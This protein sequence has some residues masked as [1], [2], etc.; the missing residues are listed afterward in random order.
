[1]KQRLFAFALLAAATAASAGA[2]T[3]SISTGF[4]PWK[5]DNI[6]SVV[7]TSLPSAWVAPYGDAKWI[8]SKASDSSAAKA[9][10]TFAYTLNIGALAGMAGTFNLQYAGDN[11][12][13]WAIS[14]GT[15]TGA[16][17]CLTGTCYGSTGAAPLAISGTFSTTS[18]ITAWVYNAGSTDNPAG[19]MAAGTATYGSSAVPEP[20]TYSM[21]MIGGGLIA[22]ARKW[23]RQ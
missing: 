3:I 18:V 8:G 1:M 11:N 15:V 22:M 16:T 7:E 12:V 4:A 13:S 5:V 9:N 20:S 23:K 17:T 19:L 6:S 2:T 14:N 10:Y 21:I